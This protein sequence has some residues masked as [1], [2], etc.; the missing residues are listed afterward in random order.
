MART[1][2]LDTDTKGT[3]AQMV[4]LDRTEEPSKRR[5]APDVVAPKRPAKPAAGPQPKAPRRFK[6]GD[7]MTRQPLAEDVGVAEAV[8]ALRG[9]RSVVD[10][11]VHLWDDAAEDWRQ[12]TLGER[13]A[14]WNLRDR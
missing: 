2:V 6:V 10:V 4:P 13:R 9:V 11:T 14:L 1:W 7:V 3:G 5:T 12:L 8:E